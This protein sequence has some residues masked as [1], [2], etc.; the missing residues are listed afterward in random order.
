M[1]AG[2]PGTDISVYRKGAV[3][4]YV[5]TGASGSG[6]SEYAEDLA[7]R[8][9]GGRGLYYAAAMQPYGKEGRERIRRH[10]A[11]RAGKGFTTIEC[12]TDIGRILDRIGERDC[13]TATVLLEC[14]SN[15]LANEMFGKT[16]KAGQELPEGLLSEIS[17]IAGQCRHLIIVT[18][19]VFS[20][21]VRYAPETEA[22]REKLAGINRRLV[23]WADE[24][25]EVVYTIPMRI[26]GKGTEGNNL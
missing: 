23:E 1:G 14:M 9:S 19:E 24:A 4:L 5:V 2:Y 10:R 11:L 21:G 22:Y 7:V 16:E 18:N 6:K 25:V 15:L 20:D 17:R 12:Y 3:M 26:K 13:R 8:V